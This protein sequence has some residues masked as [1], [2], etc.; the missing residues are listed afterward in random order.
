MLVTDGGAPLR[1]ARPGHAVLHW[2]HP[3]VTVVDTVGAGDSLAAGLLAGLLDAG[4]TAGP[5]WRRCPTSDL[6]RLVD[7][8][9]LV[10]ALN[11][12]RVGADPPTRAEFTP[13]A[14][15]GERRLRLVGFEELS[16]AALRERLLARRAE[17]WAGSALDDATVLAL[18]DPLFFHQFGGFGAVAR[19]PDGDDA[20]YLLGVV[21]ADG[22]PS[23]MPSPCTRSGA[24]AASRGGWWSGSPA[25][26]R[27]RRPR[28]AGGRRPRGRRRPGARR[29]VRRLGSMSAGHAGPG[30]DRVLLTRFL[31]LR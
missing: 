29:A 27:D 31:P 4:V 17:F 14:P 26:R 9:A 3:A 19:T 15:D 13:P 16:A 8:A 22:S 12:T 30:A 10:A 28:G 20:G 2:R 23:S 11:C 25:S 5:R 24:V 1:I 7:D 6:L 21:T 18:H